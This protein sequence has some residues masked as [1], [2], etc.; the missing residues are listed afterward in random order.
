M[1]SY[2]SVLLDL[3]ARLQPKAWKQHQS[4]IQLACDLATEA[5]LAGFKKA[6]ADDVITHNASARKKDKRPLVVV[7]SDEGT[8]GS[9]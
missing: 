5:E 1:L 9:V 8:C 6:A 2:S 3:C 4:F 7:D